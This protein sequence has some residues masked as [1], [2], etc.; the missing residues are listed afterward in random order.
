M[1]EN[2][3]LTILYLMSIL[4]EETDADH[5]L[6]ADALCSLL[7]QRYGVSCSRKTVYRDITR[8]REY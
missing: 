5:T 3:K 1:A 6:N 2:E 4:Q 8:L 7:D